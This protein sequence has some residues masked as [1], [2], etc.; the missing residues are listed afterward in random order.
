MKSR[1]TIFLLVFLTI[2][3]VAH[4]KEVKKFRDW[5]GIVSED[6]M[7]GN[8]RYYIITYSQNKLSGWLN[9]GKIILGY[10]NGFYVRANDLGFQVDNVSC[11]NYGC[12]SKQYTRMK[13]DDGNPN[14]FKFRVLENNR[15]IMSLKNGKS[16]WIKKMKNGETMYLEVFL[17]NTDSNG[18]IA[19]FSLMGFTAAYNWI[20]SH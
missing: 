1:I 6:Q 12:E 15:D 19:R 14:N 20:Q 9:N 3:A 7:S 16:Q 5:Y 11:S 4:S 13:V 8:K 17:S 18:Q 2:S 10:E